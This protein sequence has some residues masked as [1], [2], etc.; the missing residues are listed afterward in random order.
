MLQW[1]DKSKISKI[2]N[3][4]Y[5]TRIYYVCFLQIIAQFTNKKYVSLLI[6]SVNEIM[7]KLVHIL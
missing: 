7:N 2:N 1:D 3:K 4:S 6:E 5:H